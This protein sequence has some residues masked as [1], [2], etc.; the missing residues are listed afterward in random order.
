[1]QAQL[2]NVLR[3]KKVRKSPGGNEKTREIYKL[4]TEV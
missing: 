3:A 4:L 1:M 2:N